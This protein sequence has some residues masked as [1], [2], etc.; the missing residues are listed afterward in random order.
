VSVT[1]YPLCWPPGFPRTKTPGKSQFKTGL[2]AALTNVRTSLRLFG[3]DSGQAVTNLV[4]SSNVSLGEP[5]PKD[6]GI[7]V[8]FMWAGEQ[9]CFAVDRYEKP[10]DNLQAVHH[11]LEARRTEMRHAGIT[12]ARAAM[13]GFIPQIAGPARKAWWEVLGLGRDATTDAIDNAYRRF[14]A[15]RHPDKGG[16]HEMMAELNRARDE[17]RKDRG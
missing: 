5:R 11:V 8:W 7:A 15:E 10:E 6:P 3:D 4:I 16:S 9:R 17:A 2:Q 14:A 13:S 12:M 1:A